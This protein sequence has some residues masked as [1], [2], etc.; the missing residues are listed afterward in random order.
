MADGPPFD[1]TT[2]DQLDDFQL[3]SVLNDSDDEEKKEDGMGGLL[4]ALDLDAA[5]V[6]SVLSG[7]A[8][9][10]ALPPVPIGTD[11]L[12][13]DEERK[14]RRQGKFGHSIIASVELKV[15]Q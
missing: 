3:L 4:L 7:Q 8:N 6:E 2:Q 13:D 9:P 1:P 15:P 5:A 10:P 11:D 12:E 14:R